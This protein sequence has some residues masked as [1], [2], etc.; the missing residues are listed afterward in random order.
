[1]LTVEEG[2]KAKKRLVHLLTVKVYS[3]SSMLAAEEGK[4]KFDFG[5]QPYRASS[6]RHPAPSLVE[7]LTIF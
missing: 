7:W 4:R 5:G 6:T 2:K 1:M 3:G